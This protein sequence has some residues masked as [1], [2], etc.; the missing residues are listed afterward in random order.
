[1]RLSFAGTAALGL[2][3]FFLVGS[4]AVVWPN[5][6]VWAKGMQGRAELRQAEQNRQIRIEEAHAELE[7][8]KLD[9]LAEIE[10]AKG[11]SEANRII[12]GGL[13]GSEGY[14]RYIW[15]NQLSRNQQNVI[16]VPTEAG[17][18]ILEAGKRE[19]LTQPA[20]DQ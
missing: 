7:A 8:A 19:Q 14:L 4:C 12:A 11:V 6:N 5:Y 2:L 13:G 15:I 18:P 17:I 3:V 1:M 9:A 16:Y 10:R 20:D